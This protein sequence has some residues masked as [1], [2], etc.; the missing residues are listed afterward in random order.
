LGQTYCVTKQS[1][2]AAGSVY[3]TYQYETA[4]GDS[5]ATVLFTLRTPQCLNYDNPQQSACISEQ[6]GFDVDVLADRILDSMTR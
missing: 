5:I 1:E 3:T 6:T 4:L 2:G